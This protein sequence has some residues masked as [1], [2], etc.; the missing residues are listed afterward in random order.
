MVTNQIPASIATVYVNFLKAFLK[1]ADVQ[2]GKRVSYHDN[3]DPDDNLRDE[4]WVNLGDARVTTGF[5]VS[6]S[7]ALIKDELFKILL[8]SRNAMAKLVS[9]DIKEQ[10]YGYCKPSYFQNKWHTGILVRD[11]GINLI[12]DG[13]CAQFGNQF[14]GKFVWDLNTWLKTF[15]SP[16]DNHHITGF[17]NE[18]LRYYPFKVNITNYEQAVAKIA[19]ALH[20]VTTITDQERNMLADFFVKRIEIINRKL[21]MGNITDSDFKYMDQINKLTQNFN[22]HRATDEYFVMKFA[23]KSAATIWVSRFLKDNTILPYYT[24]TS[25]S[26]KDACNWFGWNYEK[27]NIESAEADT[28]VVIRFKSLVGV[29]LSNMIEHAS[30]FLPYGTGCTIENPKEDVYN[31]GKELS[32]DSFGVEKKTNTIFLN[33]IV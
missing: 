25:P 8:D 19:N 23:D 22:F 14:V 12:L 7:Q 32:K 27:I 5:C 6:F 3:Q 24:V 17:Q 26:I 9:I 10:Y 11:N 30:T 16:N 4:N 15:Q 20:D 29:D 13:T 21:E 28:Y 1:R 2:N 33:V 31:G 18:E